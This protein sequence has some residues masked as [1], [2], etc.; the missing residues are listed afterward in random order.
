[1]HQ[2]R[3][4]SMCSLSSIAGFTMVEVLIVVS[5]IAV[6]SALSVPV[7]AQWL[8]NAEYR[9]SARSVLYSLREARSK[10]IATNREHRVEFEPAQRKYRITR[11]NKSINS[12][13]WDT[14][15]GWT[16][17]PDGVIMNANIETIHLNVNGTANGGTIKIQDASR[18]TRYEVR[19]ARTGRI[20]IPTVF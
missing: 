17:L 19:V 13:S 1:M 7:Y 4:A 3:Q 5:V 18:T 2:K 11:G 16:V 12:F 14:V 6:L 15:Y 10:A 20:H 9:A 8:G